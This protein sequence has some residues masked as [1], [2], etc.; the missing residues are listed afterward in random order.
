MDR[1]AT[2][3]KTDAM[4]YFGPCCL[5]RGGSSCTSVITNRSSTDPPKHLGGRSYMR[6]GRLPIS[7]PQDTL[8]R[9]SIKDFGTTENGKQ[10][11]M[12]ATVIDLVVV[13]LGALLVAVLMA[14][15]LAVAVV[16]I[17]VVAVLKLSKRFT[18]TGPVGRKA[19]TY[20]DHC[21]P[22]IVFV[23]QSV[24]LTVRGR[25]TSLRGLPQKLRLVVR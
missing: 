4:P 19:T 2:S 3:G 16:V 8:G 6:P 13:V 11:L 23:L 7:P 20:A 18:L 22:F 1:V 25:I 21:G 5:G 15:I 24:F 9:R 17:V 10:Q 12:S 14:E